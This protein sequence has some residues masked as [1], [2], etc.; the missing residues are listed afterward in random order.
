MNDTDE[1]K[2]IEERDAAEDAADKLAS[3][4]LCEPIYWMDHPAKWAEALAEAHNQRFEAQW[5]PV[6][7]M[8]PEDG[9]VVLAAWDR[10]SDPVTIRTARHY[11][12][13]GWKMSGN[14]APKTAPTHYR[15][16]PSFR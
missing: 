15:N 13:T 14:I 16:L 10:G 3:M 2:L 7:D 6:T 11:E 5:Y 8:L 4:I 1:E 12:A 9:V